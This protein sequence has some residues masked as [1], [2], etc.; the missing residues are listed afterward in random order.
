MLHVHGWPE[1]GL[2]P[3]RVPPGP[4]CLPCLLLP[5]GA[6]RYVVLERVAWTDAGGTP[7]HARLRVLTVPGQ[8]GSAIAE[9]YVTPSRKLE[10]RPAGPCEQLLRLAL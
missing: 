10:V 2:T 9:F 6:P 5:Q 8:G 3:V 4:C 7:R 1:Y